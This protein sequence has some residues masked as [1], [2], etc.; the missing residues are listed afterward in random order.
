MEP[1]PLAMHHA[2]DGPMP[3]LRQLRDAHHHVH[4][5]HHHEEQERT[6]DTSERYGPLLSNADARRGPA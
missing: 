4:Y 1:H 2:G 6:T 3:E 5:G